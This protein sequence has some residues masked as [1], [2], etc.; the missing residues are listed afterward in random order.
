MKPQEFDELLDRYGK[1]TCTAEEEKLVNA[2]YDA[3]GDTEDEHVREELF[4]QI[5]TRHAME[6]ALWSRIKP[7]SAEVKK[8]SSQA[9]F[10]RIGI[11]LLML[12]LVAVAV[13]FIFSD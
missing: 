1:G 3:I 5:S 2:W 12:T 9:D 6:S 7:K 8:Q 4:K 13:Y 11:A 10:M